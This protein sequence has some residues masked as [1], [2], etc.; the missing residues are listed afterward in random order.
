M[1][2]LRSTRLSRPLSVSLCV[3]SHSRP[4]S[5]SNLNHAMPTKRPARSSSSASEDVP[6]HTAKKIKSDGDDIGPP[7][8]AQIY[9]LPGRIAT[10]GAAAI[11][12]ADPPLKH[13][14]ALMEEQKIVKG[15]CAVYWMRMQDLRGDFL[16]GFCWRN[17]ADIW[18]ALQFRTTVHSRWLLVTRRNMAYR[19]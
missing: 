11:V 2:S 5:T 16:R 1:L 6:N 10:A 15:E 7:S 13:L 12:D 17:E 8:S 18:M 3:P 4:N 14:T 19:S 9:E